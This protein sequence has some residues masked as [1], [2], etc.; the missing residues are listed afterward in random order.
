MNILVIILRLLHILSGMFW[1]GA[2]LMLT[3]FISPTVGATKE[4]GQGFMR[5]FMGNTKFNLAMWTSAITAV[6]AGAT[7]YWIDSDGLT[8]DWT[9]SGPGIG[10][11][12]AAVFALLGLIVGVFQNRNSNA[13]AQL[14]GQIQS[15]GKPPSPEQ[16]AK[17]QSLGKALATGGML[18]ATFLILATAGMAIARYLRF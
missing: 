2:A 16:V 18:N 12:V 8:S 7:L 4:A 6:L 10:F 11:G 15:Q 14:G 17:L 9:H 13:M 1:V 5:H 3:F